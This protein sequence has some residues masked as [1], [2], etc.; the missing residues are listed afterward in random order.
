MGSRQKN[1]LRVACLQLSAGDRPEENIFR[2]SKLLKRIRSSSVDVVA[3]PENFLA[4]GSASGL[5]SLAFDW[6]PRTLAFFSSWAR[7]HQIAVL[8]GSLIE[9]SRKK[10]KYFNTSYLLSPEGR[11][12]V[13]YRKIHL[14]DSHIKG[15]SAQESRHILRG[16]KAVTGV[17]QGVKVGLTI[18]YDLRF[19]ELFRSLVTKGAKIIFVP[20][21][22]TWETGKAHWEILLRARAI[23]NQVFMVAPAQHGVHPANGIRSYG[24]SLVIDPWGKVL[25]R[26]S[27][28]RDEVL[29]VDLDLRLLKAVRRQLPCLKHRILPVKKTIDSYKAFT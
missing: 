10:G 25:C 14:F 21:N 24:E 28:D 12:V 6:L 23:E 29:K 2:V 15:A 4:R 3:F 18:C 11:V 26:G 8:L 22:F 19:P 27:H 17:I 5:S 1:K 16:D 13:K 7:R 9:P 20:S